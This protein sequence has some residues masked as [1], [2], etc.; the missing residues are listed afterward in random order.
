[1][2]NQKKTKKTDRHGP[3]GNSR[4]ETFGLD[5]RLYIHPKLR[6]YVHPVI[7]LSPPSVYRAVRTPEKDSLFHHTHKTIVRFLFYSFYM[8]PD[9]LIHLINPDTLAP[10][11]FL[12]PVFFFLPFFERSSPLLSPFVPCPELLRPTSS[13]TLANRFLNSSAFLILWP[14]TPN[15][16]QNA[17]SAS[18]PFFFQAYL[19]AVNTRKFVIKSD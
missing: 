5:F 13:T 9:L 16:E 18:L 8:K 7:L 10:R 14:F 2:P 3:T 19:H 17:S 6:V 15:L 1:M 12:S 11:I 4:N